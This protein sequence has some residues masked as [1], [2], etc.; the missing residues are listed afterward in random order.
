MA[1][2]IKSQNY[3]LWSQNYVFKSHYCNYYINSYKLQLW[4]KLKLWSYDLLTQG[5]KYDLCKIMRYTV[6]K[7]MTQNWI[8]REIYLTQ[9]CDLSHKYEI[10]CW[11]YDN[12]YI[13][14]TLV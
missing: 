1:Y 12:L 13:K 4:L 3:N 10:N 9:H 14:K 6:E 11:N 7:S 2:H 8:T 5:W